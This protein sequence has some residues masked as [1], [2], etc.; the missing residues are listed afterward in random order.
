MRLIAS[1]SEFPVRGLFPFYRPIKSIF[2]LGV[3]FLSGAAMDQQ[4]VS[5]KQSRADR[6][7]V[8][9]VY[10]GVVG[11]SLWTWISFGLLVQDR[12]K[13]KTERG[14]DRKEQEHVTQCVYCL[15]SLTF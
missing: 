4:Q 8:G 12:V 2:I 7:A 14:L 11:E 13:M 6:Q 3:T 1:Y 5:G 15:C 10:Y 9:M